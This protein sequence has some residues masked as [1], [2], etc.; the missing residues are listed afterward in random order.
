MSTA[1][2]EPA[3]SDRPEWE[4]LYRGYAEFYGMPMNDDILDAVWG[5][6]Q[7]PG[8]SFYCRV[9]RSPDGGLAGLMHFRA[10]YSPL[11]GAIVGFLDDLYVDPASRG[12][13]V[14]DR[15]FEALSE[16]A[17]VHGWS[18]VAWITRDNNYRARAVYDR[19]ATRTDWVT[20]E[21]TPR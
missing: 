11:R 15:L 17:R 18:K 19:V 8:A 7:D 4:R 12:S 6:I 14:V 20:Y 16:Q 3:G 1:I 9:A 5:W 21:L 10:K 13:G 2:T